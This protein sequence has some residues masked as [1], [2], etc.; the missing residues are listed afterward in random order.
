MTDGGSPRPVRLI[1]A[2]VVLAAGCA[3]PGAGLWPAEPGAA[4][5]RI[6][7]STDGWHSVIGLNADRAPGEPV[8]EWGYA[9]KSYYLEGDTGAC[10]TLAALFVPGTGV[11]LQTK[12]PRTWAERTTQPPARSWEFELT[13]EGWTRLVAFIDAERASEEP[14]SHKA[15]ATWYDANSSY[16]GFHHCH[17]WTASALREAGLPVWSSYALFKWSFEAQLDRAATIAE[18]AAATE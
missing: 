4:T 1:A 11:V 12:D 9:R 13:D 8:E 6:V 10:G 5:R 3:Q 18:E 17:H 2:V 16:W 14:V 7:V 15:G